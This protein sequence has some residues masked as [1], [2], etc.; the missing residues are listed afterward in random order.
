[1]LAPQLRREYRKDQVHAAHRCQWLDTAALPALPLKP[2]TADPR[3]HER[4]LAEQ[5][6]CKELC[7]CLN[8]YERVC[9]LLGPPSNGLHTLS[10]S[11]FTA[12]HA[13]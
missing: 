7:A 6:R 10:S 3:Q 5:R 8:T 9:T 2:L 11:T 1:M 12:D 13:R 4:L